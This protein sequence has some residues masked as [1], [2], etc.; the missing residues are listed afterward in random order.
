[1]VNYLFR[2]IKG[3]N[4]WRW[5]TSCD[6]IL[7]RHYLNKG[8]YGPSARQAA[9][10]RAECAFAPSAS[11]AAS[12]ASASECGRHRRPR[13]RPPGGGRRN[14]LPRR[15]RRYRRSNRRRTRWSWA[16]ATLRRQ[17]L[18]RRHSFPGMEAKNPG[19]EFKSRAGNGPSWSQR[20]PWKRSFTVTGCCVVR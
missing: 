14:S 17:S 18:G 6:C 7:V 16:G 1:M 19:R 11:A 5:S 15:R 8:W 12:S 20:S 2:L 10:E 4:Q 13:R 3:E 9:G